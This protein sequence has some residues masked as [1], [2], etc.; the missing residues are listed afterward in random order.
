MIII[1]IVCDQSYSIVK[2][3]PQMGRSYVQVDHSTLLS[4]IKE[5]E[6]ISFKTDIQTGFICST[7]DERF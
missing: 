1:T 3:H 5:H 7:H 4:F 2:S 6:W